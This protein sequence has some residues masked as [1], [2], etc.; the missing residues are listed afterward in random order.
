MVESL[1]FPC[2]NLT[3][4]NY[5]DP[6]ELD[7]CMLA[8]FLLFGFIFGGAGSLWVWFCGWDETVKF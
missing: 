5:C 3:C 7:V 2:L 4:S 6:W 1:G 8:G